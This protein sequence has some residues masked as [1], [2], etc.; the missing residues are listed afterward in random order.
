MDKKISILL[1]NYNGEKYLE[2]AIE[3]V[4]AQ[5]YGD[6]E[7][8][9][10]DDASTDGSRAI[11]DR[12]NDERIVRHYSDKNRNL[13]YS[14]NL[15]IELAKGEYIARIDSDDIWEADKL[16]KQIAY[17]EEEPE[18]VA[19]FTK[20]NLIGTDSE[21]VNEKYSDLFRLF[22]ETENMTQK[23]W[24]RYFFYTGNRLCHSS[25]I[26][27]RSVLDDAG[28]GFNIAYVGAEDYE[29]WTRLVRKHPIHVMED[30]LV[31]YRWEESDSK[32]SGFENGKQ[33]QFLNICMLVRKK[34]METITDDELMEFFKEDFY[35]SDSHTKDELKCERAYILLKCG[36]ENNNFLGTDKYE[37]LLRD[38][39]ML[40]LLEEKM[41]FELTKY[42]SNYRAVNF[43]ITEELRKKQR[44]LDEF[45][46][47]NMTLLDS[48]KDL[49]EKIKILNEENTGLDN[50]K[51]VLLEKLYEQQN[52]IAAK[53]DENEH[54]RKVISDIMS[55]RS[56]KL[57]KPLRAAGKLFKRDK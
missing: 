16:E 39:K 30:R 15:A 51:A 20:V 56:W 17:M 35:C 32:I 29:L 1:S 14:L 37:E 33:Y 43:N 52:V 3:S 23:E 11:I 21:S 55:S 5:T 26:I 57:T 18:C 50:E 47:A 31:R 38:P 24:I 12:Y 44:M 4:L 40:R 2:Q 13:A 54:Y 45:Y 36:G 22:N 9:I 6:F 49:N 42:Y 7:F 10:V 27:R 8:I 28:G 48:V 41:G 46:K 25:V 19:C 34:L 53:Q